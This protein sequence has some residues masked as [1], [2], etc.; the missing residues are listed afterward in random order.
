MQQR[1]QK[2]NKQGGGR[3]VCHHWQRS[4][5]GLVC[6]VRSAGPPCRSVCCL[7]RNTNPQ[8][9]R[10]DAR[11]QGLV[12]VRSSPMLPF[13]VGFVFTAACMYACN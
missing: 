7:Q 8:D 10:A 6:A 11:C 9:H 1:F 4:Q 5:C 13:D 2:L 12:S 3:P